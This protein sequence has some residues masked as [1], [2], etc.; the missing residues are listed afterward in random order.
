MKR[1]MIVAGLKARPVRTTV[2]IL[3]VALE[4]MLILVVVGLTT[5]MTEETANRTTGVGGEI[6]V[7][8]PGSASFVA[9][10]QNSM[11]VAIGDLI[12]SKVPGVRAVTPVQVEL[13]TKD[14]IEMLYGID[15]P[16]FNAVSG[17]FHWIDGGIF[18][19][20]TDIVVNDMWA[21]SKNVKPGD[22]TEVMSH[23]FRVTGIVEHGQGARVF[24]SMAGMAQLT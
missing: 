3:A 14:G 9:L 18:R 13:N 15:V 6:L 17:G 24:M 4:V 7:L 23:K 1:Q 5:G 11:P 20:P 2:S 8:P 10:T 22:E 19:A 16:S 21:K 12:A